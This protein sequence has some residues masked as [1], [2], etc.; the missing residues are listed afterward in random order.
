MAYA[1]WLDSDVYV[2]AHVDGGVTCMSCPLNPPNDSGF[3]DSAWM[4]SADEVV[5]HMRRHRDAGH[6][7]PVSML[8]ANTYEDADFTRR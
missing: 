7:F 5:A 6:D 2:F 1:R 8:D 4:H 3:S